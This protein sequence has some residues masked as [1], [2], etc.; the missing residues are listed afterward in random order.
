[1]SSQPNYWNREAYASSSSSF[2]AKEGQAPVKEARIVSLS[3]PGDPNNAPLEGGNDQLP[4][5]SRLLQV[6]GKLEDLDLEALQTEKANVAFVSPGV[7]REA[8]AGLIEAIPSL[9][10][11]HSRSAGIDVL[12]SETLKNSPDELVMTNAKG[13]F[14]STLAEYTMLACGYFAKDLP[15]LLKNKNEGKWM[16][17]SVLELRGATLGVVG[18]GD[19]GRAAAKLA[20]AYGMKVIALRKNVPSPEA[21]AA[22]P[23]CDVV[24]G[25][26]KENLNR[27]FSESD[28]VLCSAPLTEETEKMIGKDQFDHAKEDCVFINV[29]RG[30]VVDEEALIEA[31]KDGRLKGAGLDVFTKEPLDEDSELWTLDNVLLSPHNMDQTDTFM[32]ESTQFFVNENLPRFLHGETLLNPVNKKKQVTNSNSATHQ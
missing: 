2:K 28:Y 26:G 25:D 23:C 7:T 11:I 31:L 4:Q 9:E 29:G 27:L 8:L 20:K 17:Y 22:D 3:F 30:P 21:I 6:G 1:M 18:Y 10:W 15:L 12:T 16:K 13:A 32:L 14:S 19:I 5:G 24:Y